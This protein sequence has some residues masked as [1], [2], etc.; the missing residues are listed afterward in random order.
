MG[1]RSDVVL[2]VCKES[3]TAALISDKIPALLKSHSNKTFDKGI[4]WKFEGIK[5]SDHYEEI[6]EVDV[7]LSELGDVDYG[8][9]RTG[10]NKEDIEERG[11]P[12]EFDIEIYVE[13]DSPFER[14]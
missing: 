3:Y 1:Y 2:A 4:Y 5:W 9:V 10:E 6:G 8:F 7:F 13:I 14:E 12:S 11:D